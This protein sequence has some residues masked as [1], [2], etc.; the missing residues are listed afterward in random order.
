MSNLITFSGVVYANEDATT[1]T[2]FT[3]FSLDSASNETLTSIRNRLGSGK[4]INMGFEGPALL[5]RLAELEAIECL[6]VTN[7]GQPYALSDGTFIA[8]ARVGELVTITGALADG[9]ER[10]EAGIITNL[11]ASVRGGKHAQ[12][13][14]FVFY[15]CDRLRFTNS[16]DYLTATGA[17]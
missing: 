16:S 6:Q 13:I 15:P 5:D 17:V 1:T 14:D 9:T 10:S 8:V 4:P 7:G 11:V 2:R 12:S 3:A